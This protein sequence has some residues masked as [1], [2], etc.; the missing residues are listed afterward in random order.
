VVLSVLLEQA[1]EGCHTKP[2]AMHLILWIEKACKNNI[3]N[4]IFCTSETRCMPVHEGRCHVNAL[5]MST[6]T[7]PVGKGQMVA[8]DQRVAYDLSM[9]SY[10]HEAVDT[11]VLLHC[12]SGQNICSS[13][14]LQAMV[15]IRSGAPSRWQGP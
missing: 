15:A 12:S 1:Y 5:K 13:V 2:A 10:R 8:T 3:K 11:D 9:G 14:M 7:R 4:T 6:G